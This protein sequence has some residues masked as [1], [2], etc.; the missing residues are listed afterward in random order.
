MHFQRPGV[1]KEHDAGCEQES[2]E[3]GEEHDESWDAVGE[4]VLDPSVIHNH[5]CHV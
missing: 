4:V 3:G 2:A 5:R 1:A